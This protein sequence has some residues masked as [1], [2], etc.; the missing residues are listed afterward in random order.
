MPEQYNVYLD[1]TQIGYLRLRHGCFSAFYPD[2]GGDHVYA[3]STR[4]DG[5]FAPDERQGFLDE[6]VKAL[7]ET[8]A[9]AG[10]NQ[11]I[12]LD[13][14]VSAVNEDGTLEP[15]ATFDAQPGGSD[16][17]WDEAMGGDDED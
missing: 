6:A 1:D 15:H 7:L 9:T 16:D 11:E 4:G 8:H 3:A 13:G 12:D 10:E 14:G 5:E 17:P 2:H